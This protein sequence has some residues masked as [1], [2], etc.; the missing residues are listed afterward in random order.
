LQ[1]VGGRDHVAGLQ[2]T[3]VYNVKH[4]SPAGQ[5]QTPAILKA[6]EAAFG[7][8]FRFVGHLSSVSSAPLEQVVPEREAVIGLGA[9]DG[10]SD[11]GSP[12]FLTSSSLLAN[13]IKSSARECKMIVPGLAVLAVPNFFHA[14]QSSTSRASPLL[15][16]MATAPPL[17]EPTTT[18]GW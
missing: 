5:P 14:G 7:T 16:F 6:C 2:E 17:D 13:G 8:E 18:W 1:K 15:I 3:G 4:Y 10:V 11:L 12:L 9:G